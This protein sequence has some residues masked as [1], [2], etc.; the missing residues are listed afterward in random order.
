[1]NKEISLKKFFIF[2]GLLSLLVIL[3]F[4]VIIPFFKNRQT[5]KDIVKYC[6][7]SVCGE[8]NKTCYHYTLN[9]DDTVID[10]RGDCSKYFK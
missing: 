10:W 7:T 9:G 2:L 1:M 6:P 8:D 4:I 3:L 5:Q